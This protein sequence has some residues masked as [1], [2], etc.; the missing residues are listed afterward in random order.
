MR[1]QHTCLDVVTVN[2]HG[3]THEHVLRALHHL[4]VDTK[5]VGALQRLEA[6]VV[7]VE[8]AVIDNFGVQAL[9]IGLNQ[10]KWGGEVPKKSSGS[11]VAALEKNMHHRAPQNAP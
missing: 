4:A 7:V 5:Q 8:I 3:H 2:A 11:G 1:P 10:G 9:G 6:K